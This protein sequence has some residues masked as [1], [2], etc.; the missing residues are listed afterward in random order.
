MQP[1]GADRKGNIIIKMEGPPGSEHHQIAAGGGG[2]SIQVLQLNQALQD[3]SNQQMLLQSLQQQLNA[4]GGQP[5]QVVPISS[6]S[7]AGQGLVMPAQTIQQTTAAEAAQPQMLQFTLDGGQTF[8][9]QPVQ[10]PTTD[11]S[12][13]YSINGNIVQIPPNQVGTAAAGA[14]TGQVVMLAD[15]NGIA[16]VQQNQA[17]FTAATLPTIQGTVTPSPAG[18]ATTPAPVVSEVTAAVE[19]EEEPLYVNAKQYKRILKRRQAR[20]KLEA[21]G[22]IPKERPKYLH[23]SRHRHAMNRVRG[24]GGR[25]HTHGGKEEPE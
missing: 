9:Y 14:S 19:S 6:L 4:S 16:T 22:K 17:T 1:E 18:T 24:D 25:F 20:A 5:V 23:E 13:S 8:L 12:Q 10:L 11:A 7:T 15:Q 21:Q 2:G 3:P